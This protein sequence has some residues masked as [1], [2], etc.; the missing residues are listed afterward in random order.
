MP[1]YLSSLK[2]CSRLPVPEKKSTSPSSRGKVT[3]HI[4]CL[5]FVGVLYV[6]MNM[7]RPAQLLACPVQCSS[8][9]FPCA[10]ICDFFYHFL[11]DPF[12]S[13]F[14]FFMHGK[15]DINRKKEKKK[16]KTAMLSASR[17]A[18]KEVIWMLDAF[19]SNAPVFLLVPVS[20]L[21]WCRF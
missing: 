6:Y 20:F 21:Q 7:K 2:D 18:S 8:F 13:S 11:C 14:S 19:R 4:R 17:L 10:P 15:F 5:F 12:F 1:C 9:F 16:K 3:S